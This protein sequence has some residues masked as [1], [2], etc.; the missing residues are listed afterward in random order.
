MQITTPISIVAALL[1][2]LFFILWIISNK[3]HS[4][5]LLDKERELILAQSKTENAEKNLQSLK[6]EHEQACTEN[7]QLRE[8]LSAARTKLESYTEATEQLQAIMTERFRNLASSLLDEKT[9]T[10]DEQSQQLLA[11]L[12]EELKNMQT[13][14]SETYTQGVKDQADLIAELKKMQDLNSS[15][16]KEAHDLSRALKGDSKVQGDW[17]EVILERVLE[18]SGLTKDREYFLQESFKLEDGTSQ[19]PDAIVKL[20]DNKNIIIDSKVSLTAYNNLINATSDE[21]YSIA[22]QA[23]KN[24]I[25]KHIDELAKKSYNTLDINTIE[26]VLMFIPIESAFSI[27]AKE[28]VNIFEQ[29]WR[30][31]IVIVT[32]ATL[33]ATLRAI[34][35]TWKQVKQTQNTMEIAKRAGLLYDKMTNFVESMDQVDSQLTTLRNSFDKA[36]K[37]L[38][39]G[40]GNVLQ[41]IEK[42]QDLGAKT[43]KDLKTTHIG[44][45]ALEEGD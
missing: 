44:K 14:V 8:N 29:A 39:Y 1:A 12:K 10:F 9:R 32:P 37:Q 17:G 42:L 34:S 22:F 15:L 33:I 45:T 25:L 24:S 16:Q 3:R 28:E 11:P 18:N 27:V 21:A 43:S 40:N 41:Q 19:R 31:N 4:I 26:C 2:L 6:T 20:P 35:T 13:K 36:K 5:K 38:S 23:H 30:K 7:D